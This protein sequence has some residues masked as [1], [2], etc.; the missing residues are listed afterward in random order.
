MERVGIESIENANLTINGNTN[1]YV[2]NYKHTD[3]SKHTGYEDD[4]DYGI[5]SQKGLVIKE[6]ANVDLSGNLDITMLNGNRSTGILAS[7]KNALLTVKGD[8]T[9]TVKNAPYY[10]YG[11]TNQYADQAYGLNYAAE[12]ANLNF[13]NLSITTY[14]G[15]NSIGINLKDSPGNGTGGRNSIKVTGN[16]SLDVSGAEYYENRTSLQ[17]FPK[18]VS[19]Y[20]IY[21]YNI[22]N[23]NFNTAQ[24]KTT[25]I[26]KGVESIGTYLHWNSNATFEGDVE[27]NTV[28]EDKNLEISALARAGSNLDFKKG[29]TANGNVVLNAV[30]KVSTDGKGGSIIKVNSTADKSADVK[31]TGNIVVGKTSAAYIFGETY[32]TMIDADDTKNIISANLLNKN[33]YFTGINEF[34]NSDSEINLNFDNGARWNMTD[35]SPVTDLEISNGAI[36]DMTYANTRAINNFRNLTAKN[37]SGEGGTINMNIDA[38]T[39]TNNSDRVYINGTHSGTHY[40]TLNNIGSSIDGA[41]GTVLVSVKDEKGEFKA[42]NS[43]G[44]LYWNKYT[45]DRLDSTEGENV[46]S[47]YNT[48]WYLKE[49]EHTDDPTTSVDTILGANALNYY[50]WITEND[51]LM[52]RMGDLRHNGDDEQ[53]AWFRVYGN[54]ISRDDN[55]EFENKYTTYEI[56]YDTLEKETEDYKRYSGAAISYTDGSSSYVSGYGENDGRALSLYSTTMRNKGHYLDL[57]FKIMDMNNEF[58]VF[59]T[60]NNRIYGDANNQAFS[61]SGEYGRKKDIGNNW[62]FEPQGQLTLG[63][64]NGDIYTTSNGIKIDQNGISSLVGRIGFNIGKD[65]DEKTN[66]YLKANLLHEFLGDYSLDMMDISTKETLRKDGSFKNT[67][68]EIG[69]GIAIQTGKN[70]HLYFDIEKTFGGDFTKD[71]A[72][73]A[74]MRWTF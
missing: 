2:Q 13:N 12:D 51:K 56:G 6:N 60:T 37:V 33:S 64:L 72:W 10:T 62:Y 74:G 14:G 70:N 47:N 27:Y 31:L 53:G 32:E 73:N 40:I 68:Y 66:L 21:F 9:I 17:K 38:S 24:I 18:S 29:L 67:W 11:I 26:G 49:V 45:L 15:N 52:K 3:D 48:D 46:T 44:T 71:W 42:N 23:S 22:Q 69:A 36:V 65:I 34:G 57:V 19:N 8:T 39:N 5:D 20:G 43:E 59:D 4:E 63:Y 28:A 7:G 58:N 35:S 25:A 1:I 61:I 30:G 54:K 50:T 16:L 55:I 41:A